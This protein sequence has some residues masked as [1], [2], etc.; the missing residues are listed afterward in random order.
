MARKCGWLVQVVA[1]V[2]SEEH[3]AHLLFVE[4][5][6]KLRCFLGDDMGNMCPGRKVL[7]GTSTGTTPSYCAVLT[8]SSCRC[9][10]HGWFFGDMSTKVS[11]G[12]CEAG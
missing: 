3:F 8:R 11:G 2:A 1:A 10:T 7:S 6:Q 9:G 5:P 4:L 12:A